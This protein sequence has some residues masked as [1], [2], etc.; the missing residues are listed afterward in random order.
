[1]K[2]CVLSHSSRKWWM[3]FSMIWII[4]FHLWMMK[5]GVKS[6]CNI[7]FLDYFF[8][9][10]ELGVDIF[11]FLSMYGC[12]C[13][14][15][16]NSLKKFFLNRF[17]RLFPIYPLYTIILIITFAQFYQQPLWQM[18]VKQI[19]GLS[20]FRFC[21]LQIEWYIPALILVYA[22]FPLLYKF[23][24]LLQGNIS[25][26]CVT[27]L[28]FSLFVFVIDRIFISL[29]A[30]RI[31][32]IIIGT[33]TFFL[34]E[35]NENRKLLVYYLIAAAISF[36][37]I[38][39][40]TFSCSLIVPLLLLAY[41]KSGV[42]LPFNSFFSLIGKHSLEIYL[43]QN[44]ALDHFM[45]ITSFLNP[46]IKFPLCILIIILGSCTLYYV[47]SLSTMIIK[48]LINSIDA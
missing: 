12:A 19:T 36:L 25:L 27:L 45:R 18:F 47:Q 3:G 13:S 28:I 1:M 4:L 16:K 41:S 44:L 48:R 8:R 22:L 35:R 21:H 11:F 32:I 5:G 42:I 10:G 40:I 33:V 7:N 24:K 26:Y 43:A 31:A 39:N 14:Y 23:S 37:M 46:F 20:T 29:F 17:L 34:L 38:N 6:Y 30:N 15:C 9:K 2:E